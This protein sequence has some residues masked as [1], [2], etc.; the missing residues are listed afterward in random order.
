M[1][2][3]I[4]SKKKNEFIIAFNMEGIQRK[5]QPILNRGFIVISEEFH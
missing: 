5:F 2:R 1:D 4:I 3:T